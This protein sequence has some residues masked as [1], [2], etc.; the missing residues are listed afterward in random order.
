MS[1]PLIHAFIASCIDYCNASCMDYCNALRSGVADGIIWW[2][3]SVLCAAARLI[4][5][6]RCHEHTT[7]TWRDTLHWL[8][9]SQRITFKIALMMFD[10]S[11]SRCPKYFGDVYTPVHTVAAC[12]RLWSA[13][14]RDLVVPHMQSTCFGCHSFCM[15]GWQF[16]TNFHRICEAQTLGNSLN[17]ALSG[18]F[19]CAYDRRCIW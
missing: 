4:I 7:P 10:C 5:G 1:H 15:C 6:I 12:S 3:Q 16:G 11:R 17:I 14:Y 13:D 9:I 8:P 19:K 18:L 2:L